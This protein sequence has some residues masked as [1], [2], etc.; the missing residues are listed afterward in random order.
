MPTFTFPHRQWAEM[1]T[2]PHAQQYHKSIRYRIGCG[3][4]RNRT[5]CLANQA[6]PT[7]DGCR[8]KSWTCLRLFGRASSAPAAETIVQPIALRAGLT[9]WNALSR[10]VRMCRLWRAKDKSG[11]NS[12]A[13]SASLRTK[14]EPSLPALGP[15]KGMVAACMLANRKSVMSSPELAR[16]LRVARELYGSC[17]IV[18]GLP[19]KAAP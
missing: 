9:E 5:T 4:P 13:P 11:A 8:G 1:E 3:L 6:N 12:A 15:D 7:I 19:C 14:Q 17:S 2:I 10:S 18:S 16:S